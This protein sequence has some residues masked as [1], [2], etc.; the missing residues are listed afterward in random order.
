MR[1]SA[2]GLLVWLLPIGGL[3]LFGVLN[4][5]RR[6]PPMPPPPPGAQWA[7]DPT[8]RHELRLWDGQRWTG[9]V[10]NQGR[11]YWDPLPD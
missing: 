7:K 11:S 3:V 10:S 9:N 8:G 6:Q 4:W 2:L 5:N 1:E